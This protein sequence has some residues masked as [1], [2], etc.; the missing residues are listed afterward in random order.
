[1]AV[2]INSFRDIAS[3]YDVVLCDVWGV[4][5][6]GVEAFKG[7]C[8][9]LTEARARGL[10]VVLITNSPRPH[11]GVIVQ[12]RGL[13]VPDTAYDRIVTSGDVTRALI[14]AGPKKI[15][16]IGAEKDFPLLEGL[17]VSM[18]SSEEAEIIVC[19]GFFDD[20][21]ETA[22]DYRAT[23]SGMAK[24]KVPF[25]CANPDLVVER[26]H[27]LIP[28]AGA[29]AKVYE[30]LGGETRISGK[31]YVP[32][33]RASL[34][35]AKAVRGGLDLTRVIAVGDG[36]PTDVK[37]A[38]DFGLDILYISAGIHAA[39][40]MAAEKT[41]EAKLTAFLK[42]EGATPKWWMPRLA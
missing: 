8:E 10:T 7:A 42:S 40:Y 12:I 38:Q 2:R 25:I 35:E 17:G 28:C 21:T 20:E 4:L 37:G 3:R 23:L 31:P 19:A 14:S 9:A 1:M 13:G 36:M 27:K 32:I 22:D 41:D 11:P 15:Y 5:H 33:Y 26:G 24:R 16:F 29:I 18:V 30:E 39:E 34:S 6:N